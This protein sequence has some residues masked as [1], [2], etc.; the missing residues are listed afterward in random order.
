MDL[1]NIL[2]DCEGLIESYLRISIILTLFHLH[3]PFYS[4]AQ[5]GQNCGGYEYHNTDVF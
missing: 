3:D 2:L 4:S 5:N 1:H